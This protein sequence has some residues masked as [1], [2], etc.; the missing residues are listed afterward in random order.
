MHRNILNPWTKTLEQCFGISLEILWL[1]KQDRTCP[2]WVQRAA[3][4]WAA[5]EVMKTGNQDRVEM[6]N[7]GSSPDPG[8]PAWPRIGWEVRHLYAPVLPPPRCSVCPLSKQVLSG[9]GQ[10]RLHSTQGEGRGLGFFLEHSNT[11]TPHSSLDLTE[12]VIL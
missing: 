4:T 11:L 9:G 6:Q 5:N 3:L 8:S 1:E 2:W 10:R 12:A 7:P